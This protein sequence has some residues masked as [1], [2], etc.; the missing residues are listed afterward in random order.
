VV[1]IYRL[2][3]RKQN[4]FGVGHAAKFSFW[5]L[6]KKYNRTL[7]VGVA[8]ENFPTTHR[9]FPNHVGACMATGTQKTKITLYW[10]DGDH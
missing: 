4:L 10:M 9:N 6:S 1:C 2:L 7:Q 3:K 8:F 5:K